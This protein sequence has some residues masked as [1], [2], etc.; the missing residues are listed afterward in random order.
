MT[1][2]KVPAGGQNEFSIEKSLYSKT[3]TRLLLPEKCVFIYL[4]KKK[5]KYIIVKLTLLRIQNQEQ[6]G[7]NAIT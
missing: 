3:F 4:Y 6:L 7:R 5:N 1:S 2:F